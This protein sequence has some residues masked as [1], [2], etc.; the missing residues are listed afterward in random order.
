MIHQL[1]GIHA[2]QPLTADEFGRF[3]ADTRA[4]VEAITKERVR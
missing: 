1:A 4:V 2:Q 3:S